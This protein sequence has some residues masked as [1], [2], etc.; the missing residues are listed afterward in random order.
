VASERRVETSRL[1]GFSDAVFAFALTLLVVSLQVPSSYDELVHTLRSFVAFAPS[2][3]ALIWIWYLHREFFRRYGLGDGPMVVLNAL[4]LF[5]VL[6]YVYPLKFL[7]TLVLGSL[8]ETVRV[9]TID[10]GQVSQ[11]IVIYGIGYVAVFVVLTLMYLYALRKRHVLHLTRLD[12]FDARYA[13]ESNV[14]N[15]GTG[16]GSIVL[17][18]LGQPPAVAG[19]FYLVLG[20]LRAVHGARSGRRRRA[21]ER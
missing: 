18:L 11:L 1:E 16:V 3:A 7:A 10:L 8:V 15:I 5:V 2:F 14:I 4:L 19:F 17:A 9:A 21:L 13:I 20:P 6:L 12:L